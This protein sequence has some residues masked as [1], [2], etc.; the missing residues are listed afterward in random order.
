MSLAEDDAEERAQRI[1]DRLLTGTS[2]NAV[3]SHDLDPATT[4]AVVAADKVAEHWVKAAESLVLACRY[5]VAG[6]RAFAETP[7]MSDAFLR[8]LVVK[9]VLS[10]ND[11]LARL[12][13]NGKLAMLSKIG[14]HAEV[15]LQ[16]ALLCLLPAHYSIIYQICLLIQEIGPAQAQI[17]L[18]KHTDTTR[19]DVIKMRAAS[20]PREDQREAKAQAAIDDRAAQLFALRLTTQDARWF[21]NEYA[22][23]ATLHECLLRPQ[24]A[25]DAG[26]VA[27][28]PILMLGVFERA[29]MPLLGFGAP[30]R[31]LLENAPEQPEITDRDV[32][33][34][35][36]RGKFHSQV[37]T[38]FRGAQTVLDLAEFF[39]PNCAVKCQPFAQKR[40][41]G[42]TCL[43]GDENWHERP[44][45]R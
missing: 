24:P 15:L 22:Q 20:K 31:L 40:V 39:F 9:R 41:D 43:I 36:K 29:L 8:R 34:V 16:P 38:E 30:E 45:V 21:A 18:S 25:D 14:R 3:P 19:D 6:L 23:L 37:L 10:E 28:V 35:A 44:T 42:W 1:A 12:K 7:E 17:K 33:V 13:A 26:L 11:V 32:I 5:L 4:D 27:V 2:D